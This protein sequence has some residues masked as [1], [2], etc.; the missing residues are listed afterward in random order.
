M[1]IQA[2]ERALSALFGKMTASVTAYAELAEHTA[3]VSKY[4]G[5]AAADVAELNEAF[6][7]MDTRTSRAALNDLAAD[8]GRLGITAKKDILD[9][10]SAADQINVALGEDLGEG[11]VKEIGKLAQMFGDRQLSLF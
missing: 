6:K 8:A 5:L 1:V 4:T 11:A 7:K 10:V 2:V 9:F 3:N